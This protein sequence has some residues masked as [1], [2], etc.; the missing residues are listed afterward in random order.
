[1]APTIPQAMVENRHLEVNEKLNRLRQELKNEL[2]KNMISELNVLSPVVLTMSI[3]EF[4]LLTDITTSLPREN[5]LKRQRE[6][7][8]EEDSFDVKRRITRSMA[9]SSN[10]TNT[11]TVNEV[12]ATPRLH[13]LLPETPAIIRKAIK[14]EKAAKEEASVASKESAPF[15][16]KSLRITRSTIRIAKSNCDN[17]TNNVFKAPA[18]QKSTQNKKVQH[19][20]EDQNAAVVS[21]ELSDG[22]VLDINL[23]ESPKS[24]FKGMGAEAVK[25]VRAKMQ[26]YAAQLRSFFKKLNF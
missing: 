14:L 4:L 20:V 25:E 3:R 19:E 9:R 24:M 12:P 2:A 11:G 6:T 21:V 22:K 17:T 8:T 5:Y 26:E 13:P 16:K 23:A 15:I 18:H 1:M 7:S 10:I